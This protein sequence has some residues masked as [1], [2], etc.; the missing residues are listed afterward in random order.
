MLLVSEF[1]VLIVVV[2]LAE[3]VARSIVLRFIAAIKVRFLES[4]VL[5]PVGGLLGGEGQ[6]ID[7]DHHLPAHRIRAD[8]GLAPQQ[9]LSVLGAEGVQRTW[10]YEEQQAA[11]TPVTAAASC[12][13]EGGTE[14]MSEESGSRGRWK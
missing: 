10:I 7:P 2:A 9:G 11:D 3:G 8:D 5:E 6:R 4:K 1:L 14:N 13:S 12:K